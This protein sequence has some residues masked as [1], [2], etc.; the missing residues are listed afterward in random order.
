VVRE[1]IKSIENYNETMSTKSEASSIDAG[2]P[3]IKKS[4]V[5]W[6]EIKKH[7]TKRFI[8]YIG[9]TGIWILLYYVFSIFMMITLNLVRI[10]WS[11]EAIFGAPT[12]FSQ[13]FIS[14]GL[15]AGKIESNPLDTTIDFYFQRVDY[16]NFLTVA[17]WLF[18]PMIIYVLGIF[19]ALLPGSGYPQI[20]GDFSY[21]LNFQYF[22]Q[23][24]P[25]LTTRIGEEGEILGKGGGFFFLIA[26]VPIL[27]TIIIGA[28]I[29]RKIFKEQEEK[30]INVIKLMMYN[31]LA[32]FIVGLQMAT[33]TG[34]IEFNLRGTFRTIFAS[35]YENYGY[36]FSGEYHPNSILIT[37]WFINFIPTFLAVIY[38]GFYNSVVDQ[39]M[40]G[41]RKTGQLTA[42]ELEKVDKKT[43]TK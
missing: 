40:K 39:I 37:S 20:F 33:I 28:I 12:Y 27:L 30:N 42:D 6:E 31:L 21:K 2:K 9:P 1:N 13:L 7:P 3:A 4:R 41:T 35:E 11:A 22:H 18:A 25:L 29:T 34:K 23:Y 19:I 10:G 8:D 38:Y 17:A 5:T 15:N 24:V 16:G 43:I 32:G 14:Y 36:F 26:W